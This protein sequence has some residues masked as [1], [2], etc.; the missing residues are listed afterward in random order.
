MRLVAL[1]L[2]VGAACAE[3]AP[4]GLRAHVAR[5]PIAV[6]FQDALGAD[7]PHTV[8]HV[9]GDAMILEARDA[10]SVTAGWRDD[11]GGRS[12]TT[13]RGLTNGDEVLL[14]PYPSAGFLAP[15]PVDGARM[16]VT[17]P[18][19]I[20]SFE[21][22]VVTACHHVIVSGFAPVELVL[23]PRC[24]PDG[25]FD[26]MITGNDAR[27]FTAIE[28][29]DQ[30]I[31][32]GGTLHVDDW[33]AGAN[34]VVN[35]LSPAPD[36][37]SLDLRHATIFGD[38]AVAEQFMFSLQAA[39]VVSRTFPVLPGGDG[40]FRL[41]RT[42]SDPAA[43]ATDIA[44]VEL[45]DGAP[46]V[47]TVNLPTVQPPRPVD[48]VASGDTLSWTR[49]GPAADLRV[50]ER[51]DGAIATWIVVEPDDASTTSV[52]PV[53]PAGFDVLLPTSFSSGTV[54]LFELDQLDGF[55]D[56]RRSIHRYLDLFELERSD[57]LRGLVPLRG[58][59]AFASSG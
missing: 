33:Q 20:E 59:D 31:V 29:R 32:D 21:H 6:V 10:A 49:L 37:V 24:H 48:V 5:A 38:F 53:L 2:T 54:H 52:R 30:P 55:E 58:T 19:Q 41:L 47:W 39:P 27:G 45:G 15:P 12:L 16:T 44:V 34:L 35:V 7:V 42:R 56:A 3:D 57:G 17:F 50:L 40:W 18:P 22:T 9:D 46:A 4:H 28:V 36:V 13:M 43:G 23:P 51:T 8:V 26:L 1:C 14:R 11:F 25:T